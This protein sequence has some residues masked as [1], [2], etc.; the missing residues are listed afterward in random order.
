MAI[1]DIDEANVAL[2]KLIDDA[3]AGQEVVIS[4]NGVEVVRLIPIPAPGQHGPRIPG[5][6]KGKIWI[7]PD[8]EMSDDEIADW[9]GR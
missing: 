6:S 7:A 1:F 8:F 3:L 2:S 5:R 9:E 4:R